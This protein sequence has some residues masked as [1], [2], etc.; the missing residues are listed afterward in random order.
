M[1]N[2]T[3]IILLLLTL[4]QFNLNAQEIVAPCGDYFSNAN[5]SLSFTLGEAV[6]ETFVGTNKIITQGFQQTRL[7]IVDVE[8]FPY[9]DPDIEVYPNPTNY[10][11]NVR[12]KNSGNARIKYRL[13]DPDGKLLLLDESGSH[14]FFIPMARFEAGTYYLKVTTRREESK[15]FKIIKN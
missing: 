9:P 8:D 11:L 15:S 1:K 13:Y 7:L 10:I 5:G 3:F 12:V 14:E 2:T 4:F 6:V